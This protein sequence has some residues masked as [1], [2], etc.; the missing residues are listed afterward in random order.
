MKKYSRI[1]ISIWKSPIRAFVKRS[2]RKTIKCCNFHFFFPLKIKKIK[3]TKSLFLQKYKVFSKASLMIKKILEKCF[4]M[5]SL[6]KTSLNIFIKVLTD[7]VKS[8]F[9]GQFRF[10]VKHCPNKAKFPF[11]QILNRVISLY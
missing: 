1:D 9:L 5:Q 6:N 8:Y 10:H 4:I 2:I 11:P 7:G 3:K